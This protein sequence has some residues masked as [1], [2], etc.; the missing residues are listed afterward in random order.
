MIVTSINQLTALCLCRESHS[1][2]FNETAKMQMYCVADAVTRLW[3]AT[4][5][6]RQQHGSKWSRHL[7]VHCHNSTSL[8]C[9]PAVLLVKR[10]Y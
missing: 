7:L 3:S 8:C 4:W 5:R 6:A 1:C 9:V 10:Y 2:F